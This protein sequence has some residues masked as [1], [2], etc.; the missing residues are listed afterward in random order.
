MPIPRA[1]AATLV[2][3]APPWRAGRPAHGHLMASARSGPR[4]RLHPRPR[5]I[6]RHAARHH[7]SACRAIARHPRPP[8]DRSKVFG[9]G[10][11]LASFKT[12]KMT[13]RP[14]QMGP[15][16]TPCGART[17]TDPAE[18][19]GPGR[20][21]CPKGRKFL[22]IFKLVPKVGLEPTC[23]AATDFESAASTIPPLGPARQ[24]LT[25]ARPAVNAPLPLHLGPN[26]HCLAQPQHHAAALDA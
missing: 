18:G 1:K 7:R 2:L 14:R 25:P 8:D 15:T 16:R 9:A 5:H 19:Y 13:F 21:R 4:R 6:A 11:P 26:T 3:Q 17:T 10:L 24:G 20:H 22:L 12:R 23:L